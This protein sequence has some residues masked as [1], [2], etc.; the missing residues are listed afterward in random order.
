M[1]VGVEAGWQQHFLARW[2][3]QTP[4]GADGSLPAPFGGPFDKMVPGD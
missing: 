3:K 2:H 4:R 1:G